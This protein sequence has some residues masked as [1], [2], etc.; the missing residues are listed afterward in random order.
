MAIKYLAG[1][2]LIGTAAERAALTTSGSVGWVNNG[3][4]TN[5]NDV[6]VDNAARSAAVPISLFPAKY[7]TAIILQ[8][9]I[10]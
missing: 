9:P 10:F 8:S 1:D 4:A 5:V 6:A 3:V 7:L 2:R